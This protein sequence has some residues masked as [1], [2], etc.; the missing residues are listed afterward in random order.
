ME[1][2]YIKSE[3]LISI[4]NLLSKKFPPI[5]WAVEQLLPAGLVVLA[6]PPKS[7]KSWMALDLSYSIASGKPFLDKFPT[8]SKTA[9]YFALEDSYR[10]L[11]KRF[12][13]IV[14][15]DYTKGAGLLIHDKLTCIGSGLETTLTDIIAKKNPGIIIID[16]LA[17]VTPPNSKGKDYIN[18]YKLLGPLQRIA[19]DNDITIVLVHHTRKM[20]AANEFDEISGTTAI[21]GVAD[22]LMLLKKTGR[23][24]GR[25]SVTGRDIESNQYEL[26][27]S[28]GKWSYSGESINPEEE[29]W[30]QIEQIHSLL[31]EGN[32][33]TKIAELLG[34]SQS[35]ISKLIQ[36][37]PSIENNLN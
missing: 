8:N 34:V 9:V 25:L 21:T 22:T 13:E 11:Q 16:T 3:Q 29:K 4:Q 7:G 14:N 32:T 19:L 10:R 30:Q 28:K 33:Q 26:K 37:Y 36:K 23:D 27:F 2:H 12:Y 24:I 17:K 15:K 18:D 6:G 20:P 5:K 35:F 1:K 31:E